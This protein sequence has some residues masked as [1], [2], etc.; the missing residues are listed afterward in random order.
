VLT[1]LRVL[2]NGARAASAQKWTTCFGYCWR[3]KHSPIF[4]SSLFT[5]KHR[6]GTADGQLH[7]VQAQFWDYFRRCVRPRLQYQY[8]STSTSFITGWLCCSL[9]L[10]RKRSLRTATV[11]VGDRDATQAGSHARFQVAVHCG[12]PPAVER[13]GESLCQCVQQLQVEVTVLMRT[14]SLQ[15]GNH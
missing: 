11:Q 7:P 3:G 12:T 6:F 1:Q 15:H 14:S 2:K 13:H 4:K 9:P 8:V 5:A 10:L